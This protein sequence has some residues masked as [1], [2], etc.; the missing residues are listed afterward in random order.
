MLEP[1]ICDDCF[2]Q[3]L[4]LFHSVLNIDY[5]N[6]LQNKMVTPSFFKKML[7]LIWGFIL[8]LYLLPH[9]LTQTESGRTLTM[10]LRK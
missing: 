10:P 8:H 3:C 4:A 1:W 2:E 9:Y 6:L 5:K 7:F